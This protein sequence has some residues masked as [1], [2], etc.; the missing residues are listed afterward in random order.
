[1]REDW[2][3]QSTP[4]GD[5]PMVLKMK[6]LTSKVTEGWKTLTSTKVR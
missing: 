2:N 3:A 4:T 6:A 5:G 1:M